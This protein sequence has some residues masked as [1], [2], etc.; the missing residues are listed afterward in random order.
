MIAGVQPAER[1]V[2]GATTTAAALVPLNST[3]IAVALPSL[4]AELNVS[5]GAAAILVTAY[6][7]AMAVCQPVAGRAGDRF[8]NHRVVLI[9]LGGFAL[10]SGV[11]AVAPTFAALLVCRVVQAIFGA[12]LIPNVQALLRAEI[13][14]DRLGRAFGFFGSGI[15]AGAAV[16]P[17]VGGLLVDATGWRGIFAFN[18]PVAVIALVLLVRLP[19][20]VEPTAAVALTGMA[21]PMRQQTFVA[22]CITQATSNLALY[23][24]LLVIPVVLDARGWTGAATG[25]VLSGLTIGMLV[26][27]PVGGSLGDRRGRTAPVLA[28]MVIV[29]IGSAVLATMIDARPLLLVPGVVLMGVGMGLGTASLQAAALENIPR[30]LSGAAAGVLSTSRYLG[31]I[32][33]SL[34]IAVLVGDGGTGVRSVLVLTTVAG[35]IAAVSSTRIERSASRESC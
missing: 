16:G 12:A 35:A 22:S 20:S 30:P 6:L 10:L 14:E 17:I 32:A 11:A 13:A 5:R 34:A 23:S 8:G 15:G 9:S 7:V 33:G 21:K 28:G 4:A 25:A 18:A 1:R 24:V 29:T 27:N 31:S 3:M 26:L 19:R 2:I